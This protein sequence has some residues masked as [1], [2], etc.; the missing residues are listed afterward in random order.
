MSP[1][2]QVDSLPLSNLGILTECLKKGSNAAL[3]GACKKAAMQ[4]ASATEGW[5]G[6]EPSVC[7]LIV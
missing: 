2:L 6:L 3:I 4:L 7:P 1:A 5:P